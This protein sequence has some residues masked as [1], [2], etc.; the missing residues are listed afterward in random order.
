[1]IALNTRTRGLGSPD[2]KRLVMFCLTGVGDDGCDED[3][4]G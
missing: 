2:E 3:A 4:D 1:M